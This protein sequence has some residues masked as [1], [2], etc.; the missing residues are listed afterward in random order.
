MDD[1]EATD[2]G[3]ILDVTPGDGE[4]FESALL[5]KLGHPVLVC[6]GPATGELCP[7]VEDGSCALVE[8]AHGIVFQLDLDKP[9]HRVILSR[10][11]KHITEDTP[12]RVVVRPGQD[13]QY[14]D[15]LADCQVWTHEPTA[16]DLDGLAAQVEAADRT[17]SPPV[18]EAG[19][20]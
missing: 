12:L 19:P 1:A 13:R 6:H 11:R 14:A 7:I 8:S 2:H 10:Y 15:L 20:D 3:I 4:Q 9:N 17:K 18:A 16:G 5:E